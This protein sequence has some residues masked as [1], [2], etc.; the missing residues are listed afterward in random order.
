V[1]G[2]FL[3]LQSASYAEALE[4][5]IA[6]W[7]IGINPLVVIGLMSACYQSGRVL[8]ADP[9]FELPPLSCFA[10][11]NE[12]VGGDPIILRRQGFG[13]SRSPISFP[14]HS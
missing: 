4:H 1:A 5:S 8:V 11:G 13:D 3:L 9:R 10:L 2:M 7:P 12:R 14:V 6:T